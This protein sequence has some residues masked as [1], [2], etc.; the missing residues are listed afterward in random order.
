[1]HTSWASYVGMFQC[2]CDEGYSMH[3]PLPMR[4][5]HHDF[6][7]LA[8]QKLLWLFIASVLLWTPLCSSHCN[9]YIH[10]H[11]SSWFK[12][13]CGAPL[14]HPWAFVPFCCLRLRLC[15]LP[16]Y[17]TSLCLQIT[18]AS[19]LWPPLLVA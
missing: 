3:A 11:A 8:V 7:A 18:L 4:S 2:A 13:A 9:A 19:A 5:L 12:G 17:S 6:P 10:S 1:M 16:L 15:T 14:I